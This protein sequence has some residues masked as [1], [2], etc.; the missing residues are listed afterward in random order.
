MSQVT[1]G[2]IYIILTFVL[3]FVA[4]LSVHFISKLKV[5]EGEKNKNKIKVFVF[6][7]IASIAGI[8]Y[9]VSNIPMGK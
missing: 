4:L 1:Q 6:L 8:I 3:I 9:F 5:E 2:V 7:I